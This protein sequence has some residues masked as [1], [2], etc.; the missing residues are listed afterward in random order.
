[1]AGGKPHLSNPN[2]RRA[3]RGRHQA[4]A[5]EQKAERR[6]LDRVLRKMRAEAS[7]GESHSPAE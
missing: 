1:M 7:D 4:Y 5:R 2:A 6:E 3:I